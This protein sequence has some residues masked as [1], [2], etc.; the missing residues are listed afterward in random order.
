MARLIAARDKLAVVQ[1][2]QKI[3]ACNLAARPH[4]YFRDLG[5]YLAN[6]ADLWKMEVYALAR[7]L[8]DDL[9]GREVVPAGSIAIKPSA[10]AFVRISFQS[11]M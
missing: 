4:F 3:A 10:F 9:Y 2:Y 7:H 1:H 6:L 5:G 11:I 8:N